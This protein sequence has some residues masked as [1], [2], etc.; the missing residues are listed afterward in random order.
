MCYKEGCVLL[1]EPKMWGCELGRSGQAFL[2]K[3]CFI[4]ELKSDQPKVK[5]GK[6]KRE[7]IPENILCK[8]P[9][10]D[11]QKKAIIPEPEQWEWKGI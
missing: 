8:D 10:M 6:M 3:W 5:K 11:D 2:K 1:W 7:N 9:V 4:W